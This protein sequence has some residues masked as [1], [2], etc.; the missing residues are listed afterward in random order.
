MNCLM[1]LER[2]CFVSVCALVK[3]LSGRKTTRRVNL[4]EGDNLNF[5]APPVNRVY[6]VNNQGVR[7]TAAAQ[8]NC[9]FPQMRSI[10]G[11]PELPVPFFVIINGPPVP[12]LVPLYSTWLQPCLHLSAPQWEAE[13]LSQS[14]FL[15]D[16]GFGGARGW[17][18]TEVFRCCLCETITTW[19]RLL[20]DDPSHQP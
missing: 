4:F 16:P 1:R 15:R 18:R 20:Q 14:R 8:K 3:S 6:P 2:A 12:L 7:S 10:A 19:H 17:L 9:G 5:A 11:P 13:L